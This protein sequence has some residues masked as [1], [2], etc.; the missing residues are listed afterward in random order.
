MFGRFFNGP[1]NIGFESGLVMATNGLKGLHQED[2]V[3]DLVVWVD[4]D[5]TEQLKICQCSALI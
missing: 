5:L 4:E 3:E 1:S 2:L